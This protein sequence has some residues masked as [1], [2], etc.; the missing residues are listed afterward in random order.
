MG[1]RA[2]KAEQ[3]RWPG[4]L[5]SSTVITHPFI[6]SGFSM[7]LETSVTCRWLSLLCSHGSQPR[8]ASHHRQQFHWLLTNN[9]D[10]LCVIFQ[11]RIACSSL[12]HCNSKKKTFKQFNDKNIK[13]KHIQMQVSSPVVL[14]LSDTKTIFE[15]PSRYF[16]YFCYIDKAAHFQSFINRN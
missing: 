4:P 2:V 12:K 15:G 14:T 9:R 6:F 16:W 3:G 8:P 10:I 11:K 13:A 7:G 5:S 1:L